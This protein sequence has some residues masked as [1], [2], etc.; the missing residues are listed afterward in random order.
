MLTF[1]EGDH[2]RQALQVMTNPLRAQGPSNSPHRPTSE[3]ERWIASK[4]RLYLLREV[5]SWHGSYEFEVARA[6]V[7][8]T[9]ENCESLF[10]RT[11]DSLSALSYL[12]EI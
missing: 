8:E 9:L 2:L 3:E 11:I 12:A 10:L 6:K 4:D 1:K 5:G 7:S